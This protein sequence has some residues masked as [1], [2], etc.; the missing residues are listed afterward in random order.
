MYMIMSRIF[1]RVIISQPRASAPRTS[2][3]VIALSLPLLRHSSSAAS[4][5]AIPNFYS[6]FPQTLPEGP[7]PRGPFSLDSRALRQE[8]LRLQQ[9]H[10]PDLSR[11][12]PPSPTSNK[13]TSAILNKAYQTL[14]NPLARA[15]YILSLRGIEISEHDKS[16]ATDQELLI[17]VLEANMEVD[18]AE[19]VQEL[20]SAKARNEERWREDVGRLEALF[21]EENWE[22]AKKVCVRLRYWESVRRNVDTMMEFKESGVETA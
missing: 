7:P 15:E 17:E 8:F 6:L 18:E 5:A 20:E 21:K 1:P 19:S 9:I 10:H 4:S 12:A 14:L 16:D 11:H 2:H 22:E 3:R 13:N